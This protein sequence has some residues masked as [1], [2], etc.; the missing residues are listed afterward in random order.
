MLSKSMTVGTMAGLAAIAAPVVALGASAVRGVLKERREKKAYNQQVAADIA[1]DNKAGVVH[2]GPL[3]KIK[4]EN[5]RKAAMV[6]EAA[7][8][9]R[10]MNQTYRTKVLGKALAD[11]DKLATDMLN[12]ADS[13]LPGQIEMFGDAPPPPKKT[14]AKK[15]KKN[16]PAMPNPTDAS[17][18]M[19]KSSA[20]E[21]SALVHQ[22]WQA[23]RDNH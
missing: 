14:P 22:A 19:A 16:P 12:K 3:A 1:A 6:T 17:T 23:Y 18:P 8:V 11:L 13:Y 7:G 9:L 15:G 10:N 20:A 2:Q 21:A 5:E 4:A